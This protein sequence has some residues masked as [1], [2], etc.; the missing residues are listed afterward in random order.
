MGRRGVLLEDGA[1]VVV[2]VE[3][4]CNSTEGGGLVVVVVVPSPSDIVTITFSSVAER[5]PSP[6]ILVRV[7]LWLR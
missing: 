7:A 6:C 5:E 4:H 3:A 1:V 2:V